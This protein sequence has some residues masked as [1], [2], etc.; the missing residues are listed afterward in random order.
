MLTAFSS[1]NAYI[2]PAF[3]PSTFNYALITTGTTI[4]ASFS[5]DP[6]P[7]ITCLIT[8]E[9]EPTE[10][11]GPSFIL[12]V[13]TT[14]ISVVIELQISTDE[15]AKST[16]Y[17]FSF[18]QD[19]CNDT[20]ISLVDFDGN[21]DCDFEYCIVDTESPFLFLETNAFGEICVVTGYEYS[22][23]AISWT[24]CEGNN[25]TVQDGDNIY[26]AIVLDQS[27]NTTRF[28]ELNVT[29]SKEFMTSNNLIH[30]IR[31][32]RYKFEAHQREHAR[33]VD[34]YHTLR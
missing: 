11:C 22:T 5:V 16:K 3:S 18:F 34:H 28:S 13:T 33:C 27:T 31:S 6:S 20:I 10:N 7:L 23:D 24:P 26:K 25:C 8:I 1:S 21:Y 30:N 9:G 32:L 2:Q 17:Q 12:N 15:P 29:K 4:S 19:I 14:P